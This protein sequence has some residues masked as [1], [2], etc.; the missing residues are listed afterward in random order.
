MSE[1]VPCWFMKE[2]PLLFS[3]RTRAYHI[4]GIFAT[5]PLILLSPCQYN[6]GS[7]NVRSEYMR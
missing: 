1:E 7:V 4:I 2:T 5:E 3:K 6:P